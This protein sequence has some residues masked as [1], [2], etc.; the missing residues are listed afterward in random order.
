MNTVL[1]PEF[2]TGKN[3]NLKSG[4]RFKNG[5]V[6]IISD[7][8]EKEVNDNNKDEESYML[9]EDKRVEITGIKR[10]IDEVYQI[11][12]NQKTILIDERK[13]RE[14]ILIEDQKGNSIMIST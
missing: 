1:A 8:D 14:K 9:E 7:D 11:L 10:I 5:Q 3:P 2:Q 4:F 6:I 12:G 13:N